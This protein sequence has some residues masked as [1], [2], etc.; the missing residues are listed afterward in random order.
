MRNAKI[1]PRN[2]NFCRTKRHRSPALNHS[3][4]PPI[5]QHYRATPKKNKSPQYSPEYEGI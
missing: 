3:T 1:D 5:E 4:I 2:I